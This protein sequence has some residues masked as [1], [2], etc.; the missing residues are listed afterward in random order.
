MLD[1]AREAVAERIEVF[2]RSLAPAA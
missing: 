2:V 1:G